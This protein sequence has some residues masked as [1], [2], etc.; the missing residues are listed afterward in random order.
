MASSLTTTDPSAR[1]GERERLT[2]LA[3]RFSREDLMRA[4]DLLSNAEQEI[5]TASHPRY[6]FEMLLLRWMHLR[7]LVPLADLM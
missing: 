5:R 7:K 1:E 3:K 2:V 4:F 6:Y